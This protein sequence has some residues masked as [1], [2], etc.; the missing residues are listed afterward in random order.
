M[1]TQQQRKIKRRMNQFKATSMIALAAAGTVTPVLTL[2]AHADDGNGDPKAPTQKASLTSSPDYKEADAKIAAQKKKGMQ[3]DVK[4]KTVRVKSTAERDKALKT[5]EDDAKQQ[6]VQLNADSLAYDKWSGKSTGLDGTKPGDIN[7]QL[8]IK[9]SPN[10]KA[11]ISNVSSSVTAK[12]LKQSEFKDKISQYTPQIKSTSAY[13][14]VKKVKGPEAVNGHLA[15]VTYTNV[16]GSYAG[17]QITKIVYDFQDLEKNNTGEADEQPRFYAFNDPTDT[18]WYNATQGIS[19]VPHYYGAD[20][21]EIK[22][23]DKTAYLTVGSLNARYSET[24]DNSK[25]TKKG[26]PYHVEAVQ[27]KSGGS[28][29]KLQGSNIQVHSGNDAYAD[30][31]NDSRKQTVKDGV[32]P[33]AMEGWDDAT[34]PKRIY[35]AT[36]LN[37]NSSKEDT[38]IRFHTTREGNKSQ[39][40]VWA[41]LSTSIDPSLPAPKGQFT[42]TKVVLEP[43]AVPKP[44]KSRLDKDGNITTSKDVKLGDPL[45]YVLSDKIPATDAKGNPIKTAQIVDPYVE[46]FGYKSSKVKLTDAKGKD[47]TNDF[48]FEDKKGTGATWTAKDATKYAGKTVFIEA[49]FEIK[50]EADLAKYEKDGK[51]VFPNTVYLLVN[52]EKVPG[53]TVEVTPNGEET[54]I[55][56]SFVSDTSKWKLQSV[57]DAKAATNKS[58]EAGEKTDSD[59][60]TAEK[61]VDKDKS[62]DTESNKNTSSSKSE[63]KASDKDASTKESSQSKASSNVETASVKSDNKGSSESE[64]EHDSVV[65]EKASDGK[66]HAS[67][68]DEATQESNSPEKSGQ[69]KDTDTEKAA[70]VNEVKKGQNFGYTLNTTIDAIDKDGKLI[71]SFAFHDDLEDGIELRGVQVVDKSDKDKDITSDFDYSNRI[72]GVLKSDKLKELR[73]HKIEVRIGTKIDETKDLKAYRQSDGSYLIHNVA[74]KEENGKTIKSPTV[75]IKLK[76]DPE[77]AAPKKELPTKE[78]PNTGVGDPTWVDKLIQ[79]VRNL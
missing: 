41:T 62:T 76:K 67:N 31:T 57:G 44:V 47:I 43:E 36:A 23:T 56:K 42:K 10:A 7:Q 72:S 2:V 40:G 74:T 14:I 60:K 18:V 27:L 70:S 13:E 28:I 4:E 12:E 21:Q 61:S 73:T 53:N 58:N 16:D 69:K 77:K 6:L 15:T 35:G 33:K 26:K 30:E 71:K 32:I 22:T 11:A 20:V 17:K 25:L 34:S 3:I 37:L 79:A 38:K 48:K 39:A 55:E 50:S 65:D 63:T 8:L 19:I 24:N 51:L 9:K 5:A 29:T 1:S 54:P 78:A 64:K 75:D 49:E 66:T 59:S 46:A 68:T 45:S 52:G